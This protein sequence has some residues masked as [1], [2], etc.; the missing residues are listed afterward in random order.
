M[1]QRKES[2][3]VIAAIEQ[4]NARRIKLAASDI[5]GILRGKFIH[6]DKFLSAARDGFGF[7]DVVFGW[8]CGDV[9]YDNVEY[10]GWH[11]G[12]PDAHA[13]IDLSTHRTVPWE[14]GV[15]FFLCDFEDPNG[16]PLAVCPRQALKRVLERLRNAGYEAETGFE[17]EWFN[18]Q[19]TPQ[20]LAGKH[21]TDIQPITP[22]MFGYSVLRSGLNA[23]YFQALM[24]QLEAFGVPLEGL[25]TETGPG[26]YE[27]AIVH[28][29]A[30]EA[31]DRALLF[32]SGVK[33]IAYAHGMVAS[34]MARWNSA[35]PGCGGH[36][37]HSLKD[38]KTG[39]SL[40]FDPFHPQDM[41]PVMRH[42][43][44]GQMQTLPE[45]LALYAPTVNSYK[46]LVEG[47]WAPTSVTWG[48]DNRTVCYRVLTGHGK[49]A[50][51]EC[52][53]PGADANP[54]LA[55]AALLAGGL[56]GIEH[57]LEPGESVRGNGYALD[58][59]R[60]SK[61]LG[62]AAQRFAQSEVAREYFGAEFVGHFANTRLW[63]WR[64]CERSV[65]DW[66]LKRY[67]ELI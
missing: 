6:R 43:L 46:R 45:L 18:F 53:V 39:E 12:Y 61:N 19:E 2:A 59:P 58:A 16:G 38:A 29:D 67:F 28:S 50:R 52:R 57:Q 27:A 14:D 64:Q 42:F 60:L 44:A 37:H 49:S 25:H 63:E 54:Y 47:Y 10:T 8:D 40:F 31:A 5:D 21:Y 41:P 56:Y 13:R 9:C 62:E 32:K 11:T 3:A 48:Y 7:C 24:E 30:L 22:G 66:E 4:S 35:L 23:P 51:I 34:F 1:A 20:S 65:T 55:L 26:T 33:Q 15:D 17:Y 36:I